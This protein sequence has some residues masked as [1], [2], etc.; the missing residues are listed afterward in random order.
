MELFLSFGDW[1]V[2]VITVT[3]PFPTRRE[4]RER[5]I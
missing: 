2:A 3:F 5:E 4:D 1:I